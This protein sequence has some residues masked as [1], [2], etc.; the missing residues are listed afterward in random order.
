MEAVGEL[1]A[2]PAAFAAPAATVSTPRDDGAAGL[3]SYDGALAHPGHYI[4]RLHQISVSI[5]LKEAEEIG[6]TQVQFATLVIIAEGQGID[7]ATLC[8]RAALDRQT[9]SNVVQR[10][11][12]RGLVVRKAK[13]GRTN[14][15]FLPPGAR[16]LVEDMQRRLDIVDDLIL[17]PLDAAEKREF[18]R[19]IVK[20][21]TANNALSRAPRGLEADPRPAAGQ[22]ESAD[23]A[24]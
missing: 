17:G 9:V 13:D 11:E 4:R 7:Q 6:L 1:F 21:V 24:S 23:D 3:G 20:L 5:F 14:A 22:R 18:I 16:R 12:E 10:L 2:R 8:R 19:L 15:L